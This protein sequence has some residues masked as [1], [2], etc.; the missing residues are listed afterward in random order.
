MSRKLPDLMTVQQVIAETQL[1][2]PTVRSILRKLPK[3]P[4]PTRTVIVRRKDVEAAF[5]GKFGGKWPVYS[6]GKTCE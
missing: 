3:V 1:P 2:E 6:G 5:E 4:N